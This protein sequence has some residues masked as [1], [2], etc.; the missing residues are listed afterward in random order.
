MEGDLFSLDWVTS[1]LVLSIE[2]SQVVSF[3]L[4]MPPPKHQILDWKNPPCHKNSNLSRFWTSAFKRK[5]PGEWSRT[6]RETIIFTTKVSNCFQRGVEFDLSHVDLF[7]VIFLSGLQLLKWVWSIESDRF[8]WGN[9]S[10]WILHHLRSNPALKGMNTSLLWTQ[11]IRLDHLNLFL[12][13]NTLYDQRWYDSFPKLERLNDQDCGCDFFLGLFLGTQWF[14]VVHQTHFAVV[15]Q[16]I[17]SQQ[18]VLQCC[19]MFWSLQFSFLLCML[20]KNL[21]RE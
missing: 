5:R 18:A 20:T 16:W 4:S 8:H 13:P 17:F 19:R 2:G 1:F 14:S 3:K 9:P 7:G 11:I 21:L 15:W 6:K 12:A 10:N